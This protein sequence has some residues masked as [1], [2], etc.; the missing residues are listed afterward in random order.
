MVVSVK[1]YTFVHVYASLCNLEVSRLRFYSR[2]II[3]YVVGDCT[4]W[5][6]SSL[7]V[8]VVQIC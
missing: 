4:L 8:L 6:L 1:L 2:M 7:P 3:S 5:T